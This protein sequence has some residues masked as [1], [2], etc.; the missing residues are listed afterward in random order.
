MCSSDL[1]ADKIIEAAR[2]E[3]ARMTEETEIVRLSREQA[4]AI[5]AEAEQQAEELL[6]GADEYA[7]KMLNGLDD[8]LS[9]LIAQIK[10]GVS[11][12]E[13]SR[14]AR[15]QRHQPQADPDQR[16]V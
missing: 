1:E 12:L 2:R 13:H 14:E 3:A 9:R 11:K 7:A 5:I 16:A 4:E 6:N 8:E 10:R 15:L